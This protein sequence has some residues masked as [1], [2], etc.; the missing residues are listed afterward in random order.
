MLSA[1]PADSTMADLERLMTIS[2][3]E[4]RVLSLLLEGASNR[5]I[6][7]ALR[8]STRTVESHMSAMLE[9][10]GCRSRAQLLL[11]GLGAANHGSMRAGDRQDCPDADGPTRLGVPGDSAQ[12]RTTRC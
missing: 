4:Q 8:L 7:A 10:T 1:P 11:W 5:T 3:A 6:A 9:K 2:L 12:H